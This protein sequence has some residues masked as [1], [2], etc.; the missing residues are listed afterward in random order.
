MQETFPTIAAAALE[1]AARG[2]H[3]FPAPPG[4]K[5]SHKSA[6]YSG[7]REWGATTDPAEI[8]RDWQRWPQANVGIVC[9]P[10]SGLLVIEAD[11]EAAHGTDGI[12]N[13]AALIAQ[14]GPLPDTIEALSP[15]GSWHLYFK[16]PDGWDIGNSFL[17]HGFA[18][19]FL[20]AISLSKSTTRQE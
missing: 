16:W 1:Y 17:G 8:A 14:N 3:V 2:W 19:Y 11:T 18:P 7:G 15:S 4:E 5:K 20:L 6:E 13:L 12:G 9:G 10:K